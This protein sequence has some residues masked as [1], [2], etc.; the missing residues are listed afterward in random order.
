M[1][2]TPTGAATSPAAAGIAT[3]GQTVRAM[4]IVNAHAGLGLWPGAQPAADRLLAAGWHVQ[5][6]QTE[7]AGHATELTR[8]AIQQ[9]CQVVVGCGGDGTLNEI[10]Q[11]LAGSPV[12]L[13]IV[14][15]GTANVL[16]REFGIPLD[17]ARA[18]EVLL[19]GEARAVDLGRAGDRDFVMMAG[20]GLDA[21]VIREVEHAP[22]RPHRLLK[23]PLL[24]L[25]ATRRFFVHPGVTMHVTIDGVEERGRIMMA[26]VSNIRGYGGV[27]QIA[28]EASFDD[29]LLDVVLFH[30]VALPSR[31]AYL[32]SLLFRR[33]KR[34]PGVT[35]HH[36]RRVHIWTPQ[37]VP[38]QADGD[39]I[40]ATPMTF[41][42]EPR[43]LRVVLP[44]R[45]A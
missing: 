13:G 39:L 34:Q 22:R 4:M 7:H 44:K 28:D 3:A 12:A 19:T 31:I 24:F 42:T 18:A 30:H 8:Q 26:V 29:A 17:P 33:H 9:G 20:V 32:I 1:T 14:P 27:F 15:T 11:A 25:G 37:P 2:D 6:I 43:A 45:E 36:A 16:A 21:E 10:V 38:V 41:V 23:A 5:L 35:Y 40:G